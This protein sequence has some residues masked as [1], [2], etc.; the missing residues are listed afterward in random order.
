MCARLL[1]ELRGREVVVHDGGLE[2]SVGHGADESAA[3]VRK[4]WHLRL[5]LLRLRRGIHA[6]FEYLQCKYVM[7]Q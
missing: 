5:G 1:V 7:A 3:L 6:G 2:P 4:H